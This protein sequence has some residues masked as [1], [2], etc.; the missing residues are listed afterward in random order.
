MNYSKTIYVCDYCKKE[1]TK[2]EGKYG[3]VPVGAGWFSIKVKPLDICS[4]P[5]NADFCCKDCLIKYIEKKYPNKKEKI[6]TEH[7]IP[8][9]AEML[10][11]NLPTGAGL[12]D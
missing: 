10:K 8:N 1:D 3:G 6:K 5:I 12:S 11:K 9:I 4:S 2:I 7:I